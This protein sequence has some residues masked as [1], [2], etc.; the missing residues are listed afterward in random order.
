MEAKHTPGPWRAEEAAKAAA[1]E[2]LKALKGL[3]LFMDMA[4]TAEGDT[5][6]FHHNDATDALISAK[7][8]IA[9]VEGRKCGE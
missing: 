8:A 7:R 3:T 4:F 6:G 2:M 1:P 9:K 5:F